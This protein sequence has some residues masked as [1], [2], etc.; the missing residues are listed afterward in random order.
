[1][2]G[3]VGGETSM[4][5]FKQ[6]GLIGNQTVGPGINQALEFQFGIDI[7]GEDMNPGFVHSFYHR[8]VHAKKIGVK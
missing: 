7:V 3:L 4:P 2:S 8:F 6:Q 5:F 1:M